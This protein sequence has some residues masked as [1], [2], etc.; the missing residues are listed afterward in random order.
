MPRGS[1]RIGINPSEKTPLEFIGFL[2]PDSTRVL[3]V[4]NK[5]VKSVP[6]DLV[7]ADI[8]VIS[9]TVPASSIQ[10]YIWAKPEN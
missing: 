10:T 2:T 6:L 9:T 3:V 7:E 1:K 5:E 4:L 8:G